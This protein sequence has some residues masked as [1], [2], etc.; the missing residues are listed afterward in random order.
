MPAQIN[1]N[2]ITIKNDNLYFT[3]GIMKIV[4][5]NF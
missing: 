2:G 3:T 5:P 1:L 4:S